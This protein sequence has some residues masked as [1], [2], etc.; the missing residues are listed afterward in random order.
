MS[1]DNLNA[2]HFH[3][4]DAHMIIS[5]RIRVGRN[6]KD[7]PLGPQITDAQR[8]EIEKKVSAILLTL[9]GDLHGEYF[10]LNNLTEHQRKDLIENH[11]LFKEGDR[12]L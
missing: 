1:A 7:Y 8:L 5:T 4:D 2:P 3:K 10:P 6:L 11:F 12:F 9:E